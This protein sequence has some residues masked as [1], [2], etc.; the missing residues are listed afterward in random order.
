VLGAGPIGILGAMMLVARNVDVVV[1]SLEAADSDRARLVRSFG[2]HYVSARDTQLAELPAKLGTFDVIFEAVG[3]AWVAFSAL[4][5]LAAN[6][7]FILSGVPAGKKPIE[8]A[9]DDIMRNIVL[10][11]QVLFGTVNA[12]RAAFEASVRQLEQFM[13]LFPEAVR[14]L[15]TQRVPLEEAP[16]LLRRA[17]GIKQVVALAA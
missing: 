13:T 16:E 5:A 4:E 12:S 8:I 7:V 10:K 1:Y 2:A 11:N 15:I 6:G 3:T 9:L 17:G 14:S